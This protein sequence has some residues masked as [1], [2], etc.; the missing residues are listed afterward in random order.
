MKSQSPAHKQHL[1]QFGESLAASYL[2]KNG[3]RIIERNFRARYGEIDIIATKNGMLVFVEVKT[4]INTQFGTPEEAVT[5]RKL[6][7]IIKTSEYYLLQ[8]GGFAGPQR[9]DVIALLL[10]P[11]YSVISV[12]HL[13]SVT[14]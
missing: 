4:R 7:E 12:N 13:E 10:S 3:Y 9:I 2:Q 8:K 11:A 1:G 6:A 14:S 5:P